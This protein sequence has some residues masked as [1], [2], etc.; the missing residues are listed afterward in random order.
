MNREM[1]D[2][3]AQ[4]DRQQQ[5]QR[6]GRTK[7]SLSFSIR[8]SSRPDARYRKIPLRA[9]GSAYKM[10][11]PP[12]SH[13]RD[14]FSSIL[15]ALG[16]A[17]TFPHRCTPAKKYGALP[18]TGKRNRYKY[19]FLWLLLDSGVRITSYNIFELKTSKS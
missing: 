17:D 16:Q 10:I 1:D 8:S 18:Y 13:P 15:C 11:Q 6:I 3:L 9:S 2:P 7:R 5:T 19:F 14:L 12:H 4:D